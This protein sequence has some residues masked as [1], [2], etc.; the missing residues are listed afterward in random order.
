MTIANPQHHVSI[1]GRKKMN[2]KIRQRSKIMKNM[3][4]KIRQGEKEEEEKKQE[5]R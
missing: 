2:F 3:N 1:S 4:F 5:N